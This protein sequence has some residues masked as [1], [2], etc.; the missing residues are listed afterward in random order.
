M[1][2]VIFSRDSYHEITFLI[3][4]AEQMYLKRYTKVPLKRIYT[5]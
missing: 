4:I 2:T 3:M 1:Y 5:G